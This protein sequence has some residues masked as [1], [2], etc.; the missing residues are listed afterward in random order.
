MSSFR[1]WAP[2]GL[3]VGVASLGLALLDPGSQPLRGFFS[4]LG[5]VLLAALLLRGSWIWVAR[6]KG[7][8][9]LL[10]ALGLG[11]FLRVSVAFGLQTALPE[12]GYDRE[13]Q[14]AGYLFPDA[15]RR[16]NDAW[17]LAQSKDA[18]RT[19]FTDP[20]RADQYGGLLFISASTYRLLG[21]GVHRPLMIALLSST[22]SSLAVLFGWGFARSALG[23]RA[24]AITAWIIALYPEAVLLGAS[25]MRE[26]FIGTG[27]ALAL[28]GYAEMRSQRQRSGLLALLAGALLTV[29]ISPPFGVATLGILG[30]AWVWQGGALSR[31][32]KWALVGVGVL[33]AAAFS[34]TL[35]A[36]Y[37]LVDWPALEVGDLVN[38]WFLAGANFELSQLRE[39]SGWV[40]K[41]FDLTPEWAHAPMATGYGL[42]QPFLPA[43]IMDN[44]GAPLFRLLAIWRSIGWFFLLPF[45]IYAPL[46][47]I[48]SREW[49]GLPLY[50][51]IAV[52][53]A[54]V[55][56]SYRTAGN[57]WE[58]P[59]YRAF[60]LTMQAALAG[61]AWVHAVRA[62]SPWL[63]R[64]AVV[65]GFA[66]LAF[67]Q[68]E[69][70]RYYHLPRLNL[71]ETLGVIGGF[72]LLY[73]GGEWLYDAS[74]SRRGQRLTH[75]PTE[76]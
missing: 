50:F 20:R 38:W 44:T 35:I 39:G 45:L 46:A 59:R 41:L 4:Y 48:G 18:L 24:A 11:L 23:E 3:G 29:A 52:W 51:S 57:M 22:V 7:P 65:V 53:A 74:R 67:L 12:F 36:W 2:W 68:W 54:A 61:W 69:A 76:V 21:A 72:T 17:S 31:Q 73:L 47:A 8:S 60:F 49:R 62:R 55:L 71:W 40:Q 66:T 16:D 37:R 1:A 42:V 19:A 10:L 70:G 13:H 34:L 43:S 9:W 14:K 26:P 27:L 25:Q 28:F 30:A 58:A 15:Y 5:V 75:E 32:G 33:G 6:S 63:I 56:I 64:I